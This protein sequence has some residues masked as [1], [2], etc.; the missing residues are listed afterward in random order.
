MDKKVF[1]TAGIDLFIFFFLPLEKRPGKHPR[2]TTKHL[3]HLLP[4]SAPHSLFSLWLLQ[5]GARL[6]APAADTET[7]GGKSTSGTLSCKLLIVSAA[8]AAA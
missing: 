8:A 4:L 3:P 1:T 2:A 6:D 5:P 7:P